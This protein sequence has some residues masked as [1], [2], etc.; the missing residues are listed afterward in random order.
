MVKLTTHELRLIAGKRGMKNC[1]NMSKEKLLSTL[2]KSEHIIENLSKNGLERIAGMQNLS[3]NELEQITEMSKEKLLSTLDKSEH[4]I[5]NLS[6]NGLERIAGMQNLSL[7][8]L[9]Q[10]TEMDNLSLNK[11][12]QIVKNRRIENYKDISKEELLIALLKSKQS[13]AE[14][15]K[16]EDNSV[17]IGETKT[18]FNELRNNFFKKKE[19]EE[20]KKKFDYISLYIIISLY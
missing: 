19:I 13:I 7:N 14:L 1:Q 12:K 9:E 10:I 17:E 3:L 4:I 2:D 8:E 16:S 18:L 5:E 20:I 6:K 11:L 15:R